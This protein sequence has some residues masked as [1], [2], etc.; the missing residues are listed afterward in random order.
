MLCSSVAWPKSYTS[1]DTSHKTNFN[2]GM[3]KLRWWQGFLFK[4]YDD[5]LCMICTGLRC[6]VF[7]FVHSTVVFMRNAKGS[8]NTSLLGLFWCATLLTAL[9]LRLNYILSSIKILCERPS[10]MTRAEQILVQDAWCLAFLVYFAWANQ[11]KCVGSRR[12]S[13]LA[14]IYNIPRWL[15][16]RGHF[17]RILALVHILFWSR[18]L[19][20]IH[21]SQIWRFTHC[22]HAEMAATRSPFYCYM[23]IPRIRWFGIV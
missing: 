1:D 17:S 23:G 8:I 21:Y 4:A 13:P 10:T 2:L 19:Q 7:F 12:V 15:Q 22:G 3:Q 18:R 11:R 9:L 14:I 20:R 16:D 5:S 6:F